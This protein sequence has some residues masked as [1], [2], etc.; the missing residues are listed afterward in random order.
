MLF[1]LEYIII[2]VNKININIHKHSV[3]RGGRGRRHSFICR[4]EKYDKEREREKRESESERA[5]AAASK[6][7]NLCDY[8]SVWRLLSAR[9][10]ERER[11]S[12]LESDRELL[13]DIV[14]DNRLY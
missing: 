3:L 14:K 8:I 2:K 1:N 6:R 7:G 5:A 9:E 11:E 13:R 12:E 10:R 4:G